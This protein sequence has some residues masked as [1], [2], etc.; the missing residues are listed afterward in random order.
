M[1]NLL[2]L[3]QTSTLLMSYY[4]VLGT[5]GLRLLSFVFSSLLFSLFVCVFI[6]FLVCTSMCIYLSKD[7]NKNFHGKKF[8]A[9]LKTRL[10]GTGALLF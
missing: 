10:V 6:Y 5:F 9:F 2:K 1:N 8:H 4:S 3:M 7:T